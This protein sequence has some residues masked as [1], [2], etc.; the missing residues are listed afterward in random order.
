MLK[1]FLWVGLGGGIG[2]IMRFAVYVMFRSIGSPLPTLL[3][4]ITGSLVIGLV[5]GMS[6]KDENFAAGWK[7]FLGSGICG[8]FTTFSAFSL[9]NMQLLQQGKY[10]LCGLYI[11]LSII[12]GIAA[13]WLGYKLTT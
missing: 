1:N 6:I 12:A 9:E 7:L 5:I 10:F 3:I 2:S 13:A 4:N 8:G 11:I